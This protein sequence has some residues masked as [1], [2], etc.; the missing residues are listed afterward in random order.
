MAD[1]QVAVL[2]ILKA[3]AGMEE[4]LKNQSILLVEPSRRE[5]GCISYDLHQQ[6]DSGFFMFYENWRN[7]EELDRHLQ[8][9][10]L[11][12]FLALTDEL[13]AEPMNVTFWKKL[14]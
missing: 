11:Q 8:K 12:Q 7:R 6:E 4:E 2:A 10:H 9:P 14:S 3:K 1:E 5:V 13:L